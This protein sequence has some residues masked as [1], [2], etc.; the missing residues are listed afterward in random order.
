[1]ENHVT[2]VQAITFTKHPGP[3]TRALIFEKSKHGK[4]KTY[5]VKQ[6]LLAIKKLE[7]QGND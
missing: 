6:V 5:Q 2:E 4:A 7:E 3:V 1:L